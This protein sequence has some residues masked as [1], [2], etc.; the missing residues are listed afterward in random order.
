MVAGATGI[1]MF[2][3]VIAADDGVMP[4]TVEHARILEVLGVRRGVVA[5]TKS[6]LLE[7]QP[8]MQEAA[9]LLPDAERIGCSAHTGQGLD[10]LR[11]AIE[12]VAAV[13]RSRA[14]GEGG[15]VL[16]IDRAFTIKG[17]GTVVTGTL[18]SGRVGEGDA[19]TLM[20]AGRAV[21][22]RGIQ[23]HNRQLPYADAGQ[24]VAVNL[25]GVHFGEVH[26]GDALAQPNLL[27][28]TS[29]L[30]CRLELTDA[31]HNMPVIAHHGTRQALGRLAALGDDLWQ[32]RLER[33]LLAADGDRLV[34]RRPAPPDTLGGGVIL[35]AHP[36]KHG[37][38]PE[39][40]E[41]LLRSAA[42]RDGGR[43]DEPESPGELLRNLPAVNKL[44]QQLIDTYD[45][46][47]APTPAEAAIAARAVLEERRRELQAEA[48]EEVKAAEGVGEEGEADLLARARRW[49]E[50]SLQRVLN[51]TGVVLHTNLGRAPLANAA[52][53]A[54]NALARGYTNL[55]LDLATGERSSR[56][57]HLT[58]LLCELTGAQD[59]IA[60]NNSAGGV[61]LA[62]TALAGPGHSIVVSRGHLVEI[63]GGFRMPD[64]IAYAGARMIEV[65]TTNRTRTADYT[66]ALG[67]GAEVI[68]RVHPSNFKTLGYVAEVEIET[69]CGLGAPVIDDI[70]SGV[71]AENFTLLA[72]EPSVRRSVRAGAALVCFSGD[73]LLG[74]P[75]A[76]IVLGTAAAVAACRKHPLAR[77]L[78]I[79]RL[80]LAAL[81]ATLRLYRDPERAL[82]E[83]PV[84]AM[85]D[86]DPVRLWHRAKTLAYKTDGELIETTAR[87]GGGA[88]PLL[89]LTGPAVALP[90]HGNP[91][92]LASALR[93][94]D[95]PLLTR[96]NNDRVL[97]DPRTL[98][99]NALNAAATVIRHVT[100][101]LLGARRSSASVG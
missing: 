58:E 2:L 45:P 9:R 34:I 89:E 94:A 60:V 21:R 49:L 19:L 16:H 83:I 3:M 100:D 81:E 29:I 4:Q 82:R 73:K 15:V 85:L 18:W 92:R 28:A 32:V 20:P 79:G 99:D 74:G 51:G 30:D 91:T 71:L 57:Q 50:P 84:L 42:A 67:T 14:A 48:A 101:G 43:A 61:L 44:A 23:V 47:G 24:R 64:V 53:E 36:R 96:I 52:A 75:Q 13:V 95:P 72:E 46:G 90:Y 68:L 93:A 11:A 80:P 66:E 40:V 17:R 76:G 41:P 62:V 33:P 65:G 87:V 37:P 70:G 10:E 69:L 22:V 12:R 55:E 98:P 56:D 39:L 1:D 35:N 97:V 5:V 27:E 7:P 54:V 88:L 31:K 26:R 63:G 59:A 6:D 77:A 86:I 25:T 38:K 78:R 8:A